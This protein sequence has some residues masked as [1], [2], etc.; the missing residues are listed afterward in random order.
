M[1]TFKAEKMDRNNSCY[2]SRRDFMQR[3]AAGIGGLSLLSFVSNGCAKGTLA[4]RTASGSTM[5]Q[6]GTTRVHLVGGTDHRQNVYNAMKPFQEQLKKEI[7]GKQVIIKVNFVGRG[8]QL[9]VTPPDAVRG[10]MDILGEITG[11]KIIVGESKGFVPGF[12]AYNYYPLRDEFE[13]I[14]LEERWGPMETYWILD[15]QVRPT[16]IHCHSH[17]FDK[18]NYIISL[19]RLKTHNVGV[20][21]LTLKNLIMG[22]PVKND[23]LKINDKAKMHALGE[24]DIT[25]KML[26]YN[27]FMMATRRVP[28]FCVLDGTEG[29]EGN[30]PIR[31]TPVEHNVALAGFDTIAVDR[32]GSELMGIAWEDIGYLGYCADAGLGQGDRG[33]I[34]VTGLDPKDHIIK[35]KLNDNIEYQLKWKQDLFFKG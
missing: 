2:G 10:A 17:Y 25:P 35:Y 22:M 9:A 16:P 28:D 11:E 4:G 33:K 21:T 14:V 31:G 23:E 20:A 8:Q 26:N 7:A 29:H 24:N 18:N 19:T 3:S 30:G 32:I 15:S 34:N 1:E 12:E 27:M 5:K 13:N 6:Q